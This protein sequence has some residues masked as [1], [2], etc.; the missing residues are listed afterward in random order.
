MTTYEM[1][2]YDNNLW[3]FHFHVKGLWWGCY[4]SD[5]CLAFWI[6]L[7]F[8]AE[9]HK[10][11]HARNV[12]LNSEGN[13]CEN[14]KVTARP[15]IW[16]SIINSNL[17]LCIGI[18]RNL[19]LTNC[20][21]HWGQSSPIN[22]GVYGSFRLWLARWGHSHRY[23]ICLTLCSP[24]EMGLKTQDKNQWGN[25]ETIENKLHQKTLPLLMNNS[26]LHLH[27]HTFS[28]LLLHQLRRLSFQCCLFGLLADKRLH[29][30]SPVVL[31]ADLDQVLLLWLQGLE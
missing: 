25:M 28:S 30:H 26:Y 8:L 23:I 5:S 6:F 16:N 2:L 7:I 9:T 11:R 12:L 20:C 29:L 14:R 3:N 27:W 18:S 17:K 24:S 4:N 31:L 19:P 15:E 21:E 10:I 13:S 22:L 1:C